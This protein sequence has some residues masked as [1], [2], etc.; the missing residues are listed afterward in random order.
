MKRETLEIGKIEI[1]LIDLGKGAYPGGNEELDEM[2]SRKLGWMGE[3]GWRFPTKE[4]FFYI[5]NLIYDLNIINYKV[6]ESFEKY[7]SGT[8]FTLS[9]PPRGGVPGGVP[10]YIEDLLAAGIEIDKSDPIVLIY[11]LSTKAGKAFKVED[12][13]WYPSAYKEGPAMGKVPE[14]RYL[15]VR[16]L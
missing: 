11:N 2:V 8:S 12:W 6:L 7:W 15:A 14:A 13:E 4:E 5:G 9:D 1:C 16:D 3:N 10:D